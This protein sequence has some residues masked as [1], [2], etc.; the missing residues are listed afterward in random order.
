MYFYTLT[1]GK[2]L[3]NSGTCSFYTN[4]EFRREIPPGYEGNGT[5]VPELVECQHAS[6]L[7][8]HVDAA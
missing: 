2:I 4:R 7:L 5:E 1:S 3:K 6:R 8:L